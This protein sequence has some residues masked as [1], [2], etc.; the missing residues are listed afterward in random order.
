MQIQRAISNLTGTKYN[1]VRRQ[2]DPSRLNNAPV[3]GSE[4]EKAFKELGQQLPPMQVP[5]DLKGKQAIVS[6]NG[7]MLIESGRKSRTSKADIRGQKLDSKHTNE[8]KRGNMESIF[9]AWGI[10]Y[11]VISGVEVYSVSVDFV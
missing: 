8:M 2:F 7:A 10:G 4:N 11:G 1:S 3:K 5:K 6:L 9:D